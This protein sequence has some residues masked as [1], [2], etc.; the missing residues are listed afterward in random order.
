MSL[1]LNNLNN[2]D[3]SNFDRVRDNIAISGQ[4]NYQIEMV[5]PL[6]PCNGERGSDLDRAKNGLIASIKRFCDP[7]FLRCL[8]IIT[9]SEDVA[10]VTAAFKGEE[11]PI[12]VIDEN[13]ILPTDKIASIP[14]RG[15]YLQQLL[16][17]GYSRFCK[18]PAYITMDADVFLIN[19]IDQR[20]IKDR[21]LP[22][23]F[24]PISCHPGWWT[25]SAK[26]LQ[27]KKVAGDV[28]P[29]H[30]Y[31]VT[32][33]FIDTNI[34]QNLIKRIEYLAR[35]QSEP[36]WYEYLSKRTT[37]TDNTWTEY[38]LYWTFI[39]NNVDPYRYYYSK[40]IYKFSHHI[41][42]IK[43][44]IHSGI[45]QD[46]PL[47]A[48]LQSSRVIDTDFQKQVLEVMELS[49]PR[50]TDRKVIDEK[51]CFNFISQKRIHKIVSEMKT[52]WFVSFGGVGSN[53]VANSLGIK[54]K[55]RFYSMI[56]HY[57]K[58]IQVNN[59]GLKAVYIFDD[60]VMSVLSQLTREHQVNVC[61]NSNISYPNG[62][63]HGLSLDRY[64]KIGFDML[65]LRSHFHNWTDPAGPLGSAT[66]PILYLRF[67]NIDKKINH[68]IDFLELTTG[69]AENF[70]EKFQI[71]PRFSQDRLASPDIKTKA[72]EAMYADLR[73]EINDFP[74]ASVWQPEQHSMITL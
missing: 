29:R 5:L 6:K 33:A 10:S 67:S 45:N 57:P 32:P 7:N 65:S 11:I 36:S 4:N 60:P 34:M 41:G 31:G 37:N 74:D 15:W 73:K 66:Y 58:P 70:R 62:W 69:Q 59:P 50:D 68:I 39:I 61:K 47:F 18:T 8:T 21:R 12:N 46:S 28:E 55:I 24:E 13:E 43:K 35:I 26:V 2:E 19:V 54:E 53:Y 48:V 38:S 71:Q 1:Q 16:K 25:T 14:R 23:Q 64:L 20:L 56:C 51:M 40:N 72:L 49:E 52:P 27:S 44:E 17:I 30:G 42:Q 9:P 22:G 63:W 3:G